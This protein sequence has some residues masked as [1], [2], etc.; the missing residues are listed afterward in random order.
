MTIVD[1]KMNLDQCDILNARLDQAHAVV[2]ALA[3]ENH[4]H[5]LREDITSDALYAADVLLDQAKDAWKGLFV[6]SEEV[7]HED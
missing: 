2:I 6:E 3:A 7:N 1:K 4:H 5:V